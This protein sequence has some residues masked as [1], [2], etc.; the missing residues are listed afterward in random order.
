MASAEN[1]NQMLTKLGR[2]TFFTTLCFLI[3]LRISE[4][5]PKIEVDSS[6][7]PPIK[8]HQ[9]LIEWFLSFGAIPLFG[10]FAAWLLSSIF[11]LH[12]KLSKLIFLR[13]LWDRCF[14]VKPMLKRAGINH[15]LNRG[16]VKDI[17]AGL[18]Y[19]E[20]K[21]ID[22][23][24]V[25]IFWR[26]ALQFW[27]IFEHLL[28]VLVTTIA[29]WIFKQSLPHSGLL[30]YLGVLFLVAM[31]HWLFVATNKSKDQADQI[32]V[33]SIRSFFKT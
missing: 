25:Q 27:I 17:M 23:H 16:R 1:Y 19:P 22:Q 15:E 24:Y 29:L 10:A 4:L 32:P 8:D 7:I 2:W 31:T 12:N 13:Y 21:N 18:Y 5:I 28:V 3:A 14:I 26:Y 11:E 9:K 33:P 30:I 6:L 20:V